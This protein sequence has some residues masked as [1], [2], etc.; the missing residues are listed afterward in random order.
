MMENRRGSLTPR[1][2]QPLPG[3]TP[4][5]TPRPSY[6]KPGPERPDDLTKLKKLY[7]SKIDKADGNADYTDHIYCYMRLREEEREQYLK[8]LGSKAAKRVKNDIDRIRK[9][10]IAFFANPTKKGLV[11]DHLIYQNLWKNEARGRNRD[12]FLKDLNERK[13]HFE[14]KFGRGKE[15]RVDGAEVKNT[16]NELRPQRLLTGL[17]GR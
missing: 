2:A 17:L 12:E 14:R 4:N 1:R 15:N 8:D 13:S 5:S 11:E 16:K 10:R 3:S 9:L 7:D 6:N